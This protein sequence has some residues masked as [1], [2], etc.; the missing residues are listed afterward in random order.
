MAGRR[1]ILRIEIAFLIIIGVILFG[2]KLLVLL[3]CQEAACVYLGG[4]G[5]VLALVL[6]GIAW[7]FA[8]FGIGVGIR[9]KDMP[10][11]MTS[12]VM[13][14]FPLVLF[15]FLLELRRHFGEG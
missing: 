10:T 5:E 9:F 3:N 4:T 7:P 2:S 15:V 12:L 1:I 6:S 11:L 14:S 13:A 8:V